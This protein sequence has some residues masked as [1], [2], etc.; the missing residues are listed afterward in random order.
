MS[1]QPSNTTRTCGSSLRLLRCVFAF[2]ATLACSFP[3]FASIHIDGHIRPGEWKGARHITDFR[4]TQPLTEK[5]GSLQTEAWV[6]STPRGLAVA[7]RNIQPPDVPRTL[8]HTRRDQ[9]SQVDR[10]NVM[11]D[12]DGDG[13]TGYDFTVDISGSVIDEVITNEKHF[14]KDWDGDWQHAVSRDAHGW[15][16]EI[17]IPWYIAPMRRATGAKRTIGLYLDRVV[18]STGERM[19]WPTASYQRARFVSDFRKV[20]LPAYTQSLLAATPYVSTVQDRVTGRTRFKT[21][22]NLF[23]KPNGQTQLTATVNP[24]FGQVESDNLVV[25][26]GAQETYFSDKRPFFTE[27]QGIFDF[28]LLSDNS[29]LVYT[30][31]VGGVADNGSGPASISGAL[32]LNGSVGR[33]RYGILSAQEAGPYGRTFDALRLTRQFDNQLLGAL[34]TRVDH[35]FLDRTATVLGVNQRWQ[36]N[37]KLTVTSNFVGD[38]IVQHG[39]LSQGTGATTM[40]Q[41]EMNPQW[42]QQW[43]AMHFGSHLDINDF[44]YLQRNNL[45]YVHWQLR[46]NVTDLSSDSMD[47][48]RQWEWRLTA[49]NNDQGLALQRQFRVTLNANRR[50]GGSDYAHLDVDAPGHDDLL[51]RGN[52][53]LRTASSMSLYVK[54]ERP[55]KGAWAWKISGYLSGNKLDGLRHV[56][57]NLD[58]RPTLYLSDMLSVSTGVS[59]DYQPNW[60]IW[61]HDNLVGSFDGRTLQMDA[62]MDWYFDR[63]QAFRIRLQALGISARELAAYRVNALMRASPSNDAIDSFS[64]RNLGF[65][66]RY[67]YRLAPLSNLYVVYVRGGYAQAPVLRSA[68]TQFRQSFHL[69]QSDQFLIKLAY[70]FQI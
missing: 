39:Q 16:V 31:R 25:N 60:L 68:A 65:Q 62:T 46:R 33:T 53:A 14:D 50:D 42:S 6:K 4:D 57:Y 1:S 52:G 69:R 26:F 56:E 32:K 12:F 10:V 29:Q 8:R 64:V 58:L 3:A 38:N 51:T 55:R 23:W 13:T 24:D 9:Q 59:Y 45:D 49:A 21:G 63:R 19:S 30:R 48:S 18:G 27:N 36:P 28:S 35:P 40:V 2:L 41:Y 70:R 61:Q 34:V 67:R 37:D 15:S 7:F 43:V 17:L 54:H 66:I 11:V 20:V 22:A 5:P 47:S 44:G